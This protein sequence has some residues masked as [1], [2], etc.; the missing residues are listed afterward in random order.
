MIGRAGWYTFNPCLEISHPLQVNYYSHF[1]RVMV[2]QE[3]SEV[4][5]NMSSRV[6]RHYT[7]KPVSIDRSGYIYHVTMLL[8]RLECMGMAV[9]S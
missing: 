6:H 1:Y 2:I 3:R 7:D 5:T 4:F 9:L 8:Q